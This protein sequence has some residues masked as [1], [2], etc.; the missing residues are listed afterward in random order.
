MD[1]LDKEHSLVISNILAELKQKPN[2]PLIL[3]KL[4]K[5]ETVP[6]VRL[7][8]SEVFNT[9]GYQCLECYKP[10]SLL[11]KFKVSENESG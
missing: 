5:I 6:H 2:I 8:H 10:I 1:R 11:K 4:T 3:K 7:L 9:M